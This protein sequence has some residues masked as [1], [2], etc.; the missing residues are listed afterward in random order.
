[1]K[2]GII[3]T[4]VPKFTLGM[5]E[6]ALSVAQLHSEA[7]WHRSHSADRVI[8]PGG[9]FRYRALL[10][11]FAPRFEKGD[12]ED[13]GSRLSVRMVRQRISLR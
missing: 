7:R 10:S 11:G 13:Q 12:P 6:L 3:A 1:M 9:I 8:V 5:V 4:V 2:A